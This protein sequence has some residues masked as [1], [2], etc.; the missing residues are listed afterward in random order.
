M[1]KGNKIGTTVE[2][3]F[4]KPP[5]NCPC[6]TKRA[7]G[8][9]RDTSASLVL[10]QER[11]LNAYDFSGT[12]VAFSHDADISTIWVNRNFRFVPVTT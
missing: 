8:R 4:E 6:P 2:I 3:I 11:N 1:L 5:I 9:N 12:Q 10:V 7:S